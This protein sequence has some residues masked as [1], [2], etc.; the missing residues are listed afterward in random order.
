V[1]R[2]LHEELETCDEKTYG[3][4]PQAMRQAVTTPTGWKVES[5]A[6]RNRRLVGRN[7]TA[8]KDRLDVSGKLDCGCKRGHTYE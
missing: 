7:S 2:N 1:S 8:L 5:I 4:R 6:R 3:T